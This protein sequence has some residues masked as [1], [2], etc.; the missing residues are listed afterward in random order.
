MSFENRPRPCGVFKQ[1]VYK[2]SLQHFPPL[3]DT[4][5]LIELTQFS[6]LIRTIFVSN[7]ALGNGVSRAADIDVVMSQDLVFH[8]LIYSILGSC[9]T[10]IHSYSHT[11]FLQQE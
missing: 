9:S 10:I 1:G 11:L 2:F 8:L 7:P 4:S 3:H 6:D 5:F